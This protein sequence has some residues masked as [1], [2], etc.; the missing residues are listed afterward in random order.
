MTRS[1]PVVA[2]VTTSVIEPAVEPVAEHTVSSGVVAGVTAP[3]AASA[4]TVV[5][6]VVDPVAEH[7]VSSG[8]VAGV[9]AP[10]AAPAVTD[11]DL[12]Q[13]N[14]EQ[15]DSK[16]IPEEV[17][18][19]LLSKWLISWKSGD[20]K[21]YRS[22]YASNFQS[23]GM[24]LNEWISYKTNVRQ[25]SENINISIDDLQISVEGNIATAEFIQSYSSSILQNKSK[26]TLKLR[27]INDEWKIY[28]EIM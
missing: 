21:T 23:K 9:T 19:N 16:S 17:V 4:V 14:S 12:T 10:I 24:N 6:P 7:T 20:M 18:Q 8:V 3:I 2:P 27:K 13:V 28:K 1:A 15:S 25:K 11:E 22:C 26:K 5:E